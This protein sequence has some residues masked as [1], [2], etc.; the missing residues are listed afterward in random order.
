MRTR[1][2]HGAT[3]PNSPAI[4]NRPATKRRVFAMRREYPAG[5]KINFPLVVIGQILPKLVPFDPLKFAVDNASKYGDIA[6]YQVG[7]LRVYQL[8]SPELIRQILVEQPE[9]F[10]KPVYIKRGFGP[11]VG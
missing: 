9:K 2:N 4:T 7:P 11:F 1:I 8:N 6:Y 5:P 3:S 10:Y